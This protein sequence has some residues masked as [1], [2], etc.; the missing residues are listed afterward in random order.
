MNIRYDTTKRGEPM[1]ALNPF[2]FMRRWNMNWLFAVAVSALLPLGK[3]NATWYSANCEIGSDILMVEVRCP[4]WCSSPSP[5]QPPPSG[6]T[7]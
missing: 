2:F 3:A 1:R 7:S 5:I 4:Y 6:F